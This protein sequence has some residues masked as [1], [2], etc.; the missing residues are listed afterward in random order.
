MRQYALCDGRL[1]AKC[2]GLMFAI[3]SWVDASET[4]RETSCAEVGSTGEDLLRYSP[5]GLHDDAH[6]QRSVRTIT[7]SK[8]LQMWSQ[9]A[10][11]WGNTRRV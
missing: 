9:A 2:G 4:S 7:K 11:V 5:G 1:P 3:I 8:G 10:T 6:C